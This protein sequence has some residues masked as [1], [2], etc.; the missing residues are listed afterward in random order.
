MMFLML[1]AGT[2]T[3]QTPA[4]A[5]EDQ[6]NSSYDDAVHCGGLFMLYSTMLEESSPDVVQMY[7]GKARSWILFATDKLG[8]PMNDV[9]ADTEK[10]SRATLDKLASLPS[11]SNSEQVMKD[12]EA[13]CEKLALTLGVN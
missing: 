8:K 5:E 7:K 12:E 6:S 13:S 1:G 3:M 2:M 11:G 9:F 4:A 10:S